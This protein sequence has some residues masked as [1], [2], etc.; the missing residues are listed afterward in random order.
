MKLCGWRTRT[1]FDRYNIFER[2]LAEG[3]ASWDKW[4]TKAPSWP[5][6]EA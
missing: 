4:H 2:D 5:L 3:L 1:V 6:V